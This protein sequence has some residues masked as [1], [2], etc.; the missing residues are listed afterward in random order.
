MGWV[1]TVVVIIGVIIGWLIE[2]L[3]A[4]GPVGRLVL[5]SVLAGA[6]LAWAVAIEKGQLAKD[7][8][9]SRVMPRVTAGITVGLVVLQAVFLRSLAPS[10]AAIALLLV[11]LGLRGWM[12]PLST[13]GIHAVAK[14][15]RENRLREHY[16]FDNVQLHVHP[17]TKRQMRPSGGFAVFSPPQPLSVF[18]S[19]A[20]GMFK[21][22]KHEWLLIGMEREGVVERAWLNKGMD[23]RSVS[24]GIPLGELVAAAIDG[25]YTTILEAH[26]HPN[27]SPQYKSTLSPSDLDIETA[28]GMAQELAAHGLG[29]IAFVCE[30]GMWKEYMRSLPDGFVPLQSFIDEITTMLESDWGAKYHLRMEL[31]SKEQD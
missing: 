13:A 16:R 19:L 9:S 10:G 20:A 23:A 1:V 14:K 8:R 12:R 21:Y 30:R 22:K 25:G 24:T 2:A 7:N 5:A 3:G 18:P 29:F 28:K 26:N 17:C 15:R 11:L 27:P 31:Y 4:I 6:T